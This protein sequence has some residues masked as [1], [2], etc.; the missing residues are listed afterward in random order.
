VR[1]Y[2]PRAQEL[3]SRVQALLTAPR[4]PAERNVVIHRV[5]AGEVLGAI[6]RRY[7][8]T[9]RSIRKANGLRKDTIHAGMSLQVPTRI[10]YLD[11]PVPPQVVVPQR[12]LPP[13]TP[14]LFARRSPPG[15]S[16]AASDAKAPAPA[17]AADATS[18]A[19]LP[20]G[21]APLAADPAPG[22]ARPTTSAAGPPAGSASAAQ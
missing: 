3:G 1:F 10:A 5:K 7:E 20:A 18:A 16:V 4:S 9:L 2:N 12:R 11:C 22:A 6:A 17:T 19:A 21:P 15:L 8:T 13:S 14:A